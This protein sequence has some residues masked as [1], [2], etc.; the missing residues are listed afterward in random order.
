MNS[1]RVLQVMAGA[2][3]GG[4]EAFFE[5]LCIALHE[6]GL[7]QHVLIRTNEE[8]K[9]RLEE[10]GLA[11]AEA[12]FGGPF[13]WRTPLAFRKKI[14]EFQPHIVM[15]W[16]NRATKFCP[17]G[18]F[19]QVAR[20]GGYYN[21]K[22]YQN[23]DHLIGNTEDIVAYLRQEGRQ[24]ETTHYLPNFPAVME[25]APADRGPLF[26]PEGVKLIVA[27]GRLH[28]NKGFDVL[29]DALAKTPDTYCW[30]AG[31]GPLRKE[32]EDQALRLGI[33]P[34]LRFLGWRDDIASLLA[35]ADVFVCPSRHEPLGNVVL[36]AWAAKK[37]IVATDSEGP[38]KLIDHEKNGLIVPIDNA[39]LLSKSIKRILA[40][41]EKA[42]D[43]AEA[44]YRAYE[45]DFSAQ[46]VVAQYRRFFKRIAK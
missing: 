45:K 30:L 9:A 20:L 26:T 5:R 38:G 15:T 42:A 12:P 36:E 31:E 11:V 8:R 19:V 41:P 44:G 16:M 6:D 35:A 14:N 43:L 29:L 7:H 40:E 33:K 3:H 4:A 24:E 34:R 46:S 1:L 27:M 28:E 10:K 18:D 32:L 23:C 21:M 22:Y 13:D 37:P 2:P 17:K 39:D 25:G